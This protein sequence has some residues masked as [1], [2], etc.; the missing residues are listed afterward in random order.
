[1]HSIFYFNTFAQETIPQKSKKCY[2]AAM[3][4]TAILFDHDGTL[5]D[6]IDAVAKC[7]NK[8]FV[9]NGFREHSSTEILA[10]FPY[11]TGER[12]QFH[13][14]ADDAFSDKMSDEF[15]SCMRNEGIEHLKIYPGIQEVLDS[16]AVSGYSMGVVSN[17]QGIFVRKAAAHL[18]YAYDLE[19]ILGEEN[20]KACKPAPDGLLQACAG[21]AALPENCWYIGDTVSDHEAARAAG[22]KSGLVTWGVQTEEILSACGSDA[23]FKTP[24]EL[25]EF[26]IR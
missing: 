2:K 24:E 7:T 23:V 17:N 20:V 15:F 12:F 4:K 6:S 26:F 8:V 13:T 10:G 19:I 5:V 16:L 3:K 21:L 25:K 9:N 22:M 18:H 14:N 11:P 1:M